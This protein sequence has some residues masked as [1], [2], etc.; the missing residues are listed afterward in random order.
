MASAEAT[1]VAAGGSSRSGATAAAAAAAA[2]A[3]AEFARVRHLPAANSNAEATVQIVLP[4]QG[5]QRS[6]NRPADGTVSSTLKRMALSLASN[7]SKTKKNKRKEHSG[8]TANGVSVALPTAVLTHCS[9]D[10]NVEVDGATA[11]KSAWQTGAILHLGST[12]WRVVAN[13]PSV[14][15]LHVPGSSRPMADYPLH[16]LA[17]A[18]YA[19]SLT[20]EWSRQASPQ[21]N[22]SQAR[23]DAA[24]PDSSVVVGRG[25]TYTP[26]EADL[27][28][29]I[30]LTCVA[31]G[32]DDLPND[33]QSLIQP[34]RV[35][36]A[37]VE[38][39][40]VEAEMNSLRVL[41][42]QQGWEK[43][44][45]AVTDSFAIMSYNILANVYANTDEART[46]L[47]P[48][49]PATALDVVYRIQRVLR[50][51][52]SALPTIVCL[53]EVDR[54]VYEEWL[55]PVLGAAGYNDGHYV[56]KSTSSREGVCTFVWSGDG[57]DGGRGWMVEHHEACHL[58]GPAP[59]DCVSNALATQ[60]R[61]GE[62][63]VAALTKL[64]TVAQFLWLFPKDSGMA[65]GGGRK[66]LIA[67]THLF[68]HP[69]CSHI[70]ALQLQRLLSAAF[71]RL[72]WASSGEV[73]AFSVDN[74]EFV[75]CGDLNAQP[76]SA[77]GMFL[78]DGRL[79]A[80]HPDWMD[81][82]VWF[83]WKP[84]A[85]EAVQMQAAH[86]R[87][88]A[89]EEAERRSR[90]SNTHSVLNGDLTTIASAVTDGAH[91]AAA[92]P[93]EEHEH[94]LGV[95]LSHPFQFS[96][97]EHLWTTKTTGFVG[98]LDYILPHSSGRLRISAVA[99]MPFE[100]PGTMPSLSAPSDHASLLY[101]F[102]WN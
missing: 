16:A 89:D 64:G 2:A 85:E 6:F 93:G 95:E 92:T 59:L 9:G 80:T 48:D 79:D 100:K 99:P 101:K 74:R 36:T 21:R 62:Q 77:A 68:F 35:V 47:F 42:E 29:A 49:C 58:G 72:S 38:L 98:R 8:G 46:T 83:R 24:L 28:C 53:Q 63:T 50:E 17:C 84:T 57:A 82:N 44:T 18:E 56:E 14:V 13:V 41:R 7:R 88:Q 51:I 27:G 102:V 96:W 19:K 40:S 15:S 30:Q 76:H 75:L 71:S 22:E 66:L 90:G 32:A 3:S 45:I 10:G 81:Y 20:W 94:T 54:S 60:G 52:V 87:Q 11:N 43:C 25:S 5:S 33:I 31:K 55:Q 70:R 26:T 4:W 67:N 39:C 91:L 65:T 78:R 73:A 12:K 69:L 86:R 1:V 34:M 61:A 23:K 37:P 97:T